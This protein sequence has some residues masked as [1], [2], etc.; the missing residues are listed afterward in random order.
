MV[1]SFLGGELGSPLPSEKLQPITE[2]ADHGI[3][4][5]A[6]AGEPLPVSEDYALTKNLRS[7]ACLARDEK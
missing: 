2:G 7:P 1:L 3:Q 6:H 4:E 5:A